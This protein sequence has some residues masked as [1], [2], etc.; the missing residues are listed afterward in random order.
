[1]KAAF[2]LTAVLTLAATASGCARVS[3]DPAELRTAEVD[4]VE[5][6]I[7]DPA[8]A[9]RMLQLIGQRDQLV[10]ET[11]VML[12]QY[13]REMAALN[14]DYGARREVVVEIIDV[15]N[16]ER[17]DI[18]LRFIDLINEMKRATTSAEWKVIAGFQ[19]EYFDPRRMVYRQAAGG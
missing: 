10:A 14:A 8:R 19:L 1:M 5:S 16:R 11:R 15:Y 4:L 18:Q 13:R 7:T 6:T 17:A 2:F 3:P 12:E 9:E